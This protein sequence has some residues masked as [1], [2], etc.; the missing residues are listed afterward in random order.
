MNNHTIE[1]VSAVIKPNA[2]EKLHKAALAYGGRVPSQK[3]NGRSKEGGGRLACKE[4]GFARPTLWNAINGIAIH[5]GSAKLIC[6]TLGLN[7]HDTFDKIIGTK[8]YMK[9]SIMKYKRVL[10]CIFNYAIQIE[11][12][13]TNYASSAYLKKVIGGEESKEVELLTEDEYNNL[14]EVMESKPVSDTI[15]IYLMSMLGLRTCEAC[16]LSWSD[17]DFENRIL[18]VRRNRLYLKM[19]GKKSEIIERTVKT[20]YSIRDL[21]L[22]HAILLKLQECKLE[23]YDRIQSCNS[24]FDNSDAVFCNFDGTPAN[25]QRINKS[26][27]KFLI[28]AGCRA[29]TPHSL[30]HYWITAMIDNGA[31]ITTVSKLAGHATPE[32]TLKIYTHYRKDTDNSKEIFE[33]VFAKPSPTKNSVQA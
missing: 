8:N 22:H 16:G 15:P 14:L 23:W 17:V 24:E 30:R 33:K 18:R 20:K 1:S 12:V 26:L 19:A 29:A 32:I 31:K 7:V 21:H 10:S 5:W 27:K 28:E 3:S 4:G 9:E 11:L 2:K 6:K 13:T 25:P